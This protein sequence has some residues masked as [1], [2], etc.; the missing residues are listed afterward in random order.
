M[1]KEKTTPEETGAEG[2]GNTTNVGGMLNRFKRKASDIL[3]GGIDDKDE[4]SLPEEKTENK[5]VPD[6]K[7]A[8][9]I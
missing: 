6:V 3:A 1:I 7:A 2:N 9:E 8:E 5:A 4:A